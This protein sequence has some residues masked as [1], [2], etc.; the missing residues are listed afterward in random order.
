MKWLVGVMGL[1][2]A[3]TASL[4]LYMA[5]NYPSRRRNCTIALACGIVIPLVLMAT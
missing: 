2:L 5:F 4:G 1:A 3:A